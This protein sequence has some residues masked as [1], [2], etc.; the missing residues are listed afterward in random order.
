MN[1]VSKDRPLRKA[2]A[3]LAIVV[4]GVMIALAADSWRERVISARVE[5]QYVARLQGD[6][7]DGLERLAEQRATF[8]KVAGAAATL[9]AAM[10]E[11]VS[12]LTDDQ[13]IATIL[14]AA[15][16]GFVP[17]QLGSDVTY[18]EM[19]ASGQLALIGSPAVRQGL[20]AYYRNSERLAE[21]LQALP[22]VNNRVGELTGYLP[23]EFR[24]RGRDLTAAD[25]RRLT[26]ELWPDPE[27]ARE[28][29]LLNAQLVFN[30]RVFEQVIDQ[31]RALLASL[32]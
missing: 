15:Q 22:R 29:R 17:Q 10:D 18:R 6:L 20:V 30:D 26:D 9:A 1:Q 8:G 16:M 25:R 5:D 21:A 28:L 12:P 3:E 11:P 31:G 19:V 14:E 2:L 7:G 32:D 24:T 4:L 13:L 27:F 23:S